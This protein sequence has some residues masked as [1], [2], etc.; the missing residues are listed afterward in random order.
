MCQDHDHHDQP[1]TL[2][3]DP[4]LRPAG[5]TRRGF[6]GGAAAVGA[7]A[8]I[9]FEPSRAAASVTFDGNGSQSMAM[10]VHSSFSEF[11]ASMDAQLFQAQTN[12]IDVLWWTDHDYR[13]QQVNYRTTVHFTSLTAETTAGE[14]QPWLWQKRTSGS[15]TPAS[16][17][18]IAS[19]GSPND[20]VAGG[21]LTVTAESASVGIPASLGYYAETKQ[22][23]WN[24]R[25]NLFGQTFTLEVLPKSI[26]LDGYL[27][28]QI[29]TSYH[30]ATGGRPAGNYLLSYRFGGSGVPGSVV[31]NGT[32]A[33]VTVPVVAGEWNT[34]SVTPT[35]DIAAAWPDMHPHDFN[36]YGLTF[37]AVSYGLAV[38][39]NFDY[40]RISRQYTSGNFPLATQQ[41]IETFYGPLYPA[42]TQRQGVEISGSE[43]HVNWFGGNVTLSSWTGG[44]AA[45]YSDYLKHQISDCHAAGGVASYNHPFG[46]AGGPL[47][48]ASTQDTKRAQVA[49]EL[50][51]SKALGADVLEVGYIAR[52]GCDLAHHLG[53]WDV[54]SRNAVFLTGNGVN[55]NHNGRNWYGQQNNWITSVWAPSAAEADLLAALRAGRGW[56]NS[57][58]ARCSLDLLVDGVCPM[59]SVSL[60]SVANRKVQ[61]FASGLPSGGTVQVL[62]GNVDYAGTADPTPNTMVIAS[63]TVTQAATSPTVTVDT[64]S[65]CF[66]RTIVRNYSGAVVGTSNP[67]WL[68]RQI[69]SS[70]IPVARAC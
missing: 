53:V 43:P 44:T 7:G 63:F 45:A 57:L 37:S 27:E 24:E 35:N 8:L 36:C 4:S 55:D 58:R 39:G 23:K 10:H 17:G 70:G 46:T 40:V 21:S 60:S 29:A 48:A 42:V 33:I 20:P 16:T 1:E 61:V 54:L 30:P 3:S 13:M 38:S 68:L 47:L 56:S 6:L 2:P 59:G 9:G 12:K 66:V 65:S 50:L 49:S 34:V 69:P 67:V 28:F 62:R 32:T 11:D 51:T 19:E 15:L 22:S 64:T 18:G 14:G 31:A 5:I 52:S 26:G 25:A 41:E